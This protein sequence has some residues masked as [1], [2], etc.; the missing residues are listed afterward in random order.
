MG[1]WVIICKHLRTLFLLHQVKSDFDETWYDWYED[2]GL[3]ITALHAS[4]Y[5]LAALAFPVAL[6]CCMLLHILKALN[7]FGIIWLKQWLQHTVQH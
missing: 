4:W 5:N 1:D 7:L 3:Q 2:K 6:Q